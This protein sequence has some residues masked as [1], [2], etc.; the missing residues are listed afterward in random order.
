MG[1]HKDALPAACATSGTQSAGMAAGGLLSDVCQ[2]GSPAHTPYGCA[3]DPGSGKRL[4]T[5]P[6]YLI[7]LLFHTQH[8]SVLHQ[9]GREYRNHC[10]TFTML[11]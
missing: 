10:W 11:P 7:Y 9:A 5:S 1:P 8:T 6:L 3:E 2:R 4:Q